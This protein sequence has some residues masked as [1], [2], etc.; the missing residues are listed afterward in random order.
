MISLQKLLVNISKENN[1]G[2]ALQFNIKI[3]SKVKKRENNLK[4]ENDIATKFK[5]SQNQRTKTG[6]ANRS[7]GTVDA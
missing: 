1:L 3:F 4:F 5:E 6:L 2:T 7:C